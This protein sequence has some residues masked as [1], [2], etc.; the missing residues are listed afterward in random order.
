MN[1]DLLHKALTPP[2]GMVDAV[3]DTDISTISLT[4]KTTYWTLAIA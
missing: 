3:I 4:D 1:N 2:E